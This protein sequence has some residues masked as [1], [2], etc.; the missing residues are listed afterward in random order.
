[1]TYLR[2]QGVNNVGFVWNLGG[3]Q[4]SQLSLMGIEG[5]VKAYY[6]GDDYTDIVSFDAYPPGPQNQD[7]YLALTKDAP[8]NKPFMFGEIGAAA[9]NPP[10]SENTGDIANALDYVTT[11]F[12]DA[13]AVCVWPGT[14]AIPDQTGIGK[15]GDGM[16][17][18]MANPYVINLGGL[19]GGF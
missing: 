19:P 15:P 16:F 1:M 17:K 6:P 11:N 7:T 10:P 12:T 4:A 13:V 14:D 18:F 9:G 3:G 2:N 5:F 8:F